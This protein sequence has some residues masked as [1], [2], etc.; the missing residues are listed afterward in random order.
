MLIIASTGTTDVV[1]AAML[2]LAVLL[3]WRPGASMAVL[4]V[5]GWFKL[6]PFALVP[7]WLAP[8][9][10]RRLAASIGSLAA[11]SA[12]A[13]ALALALG[14]LHGLAAMAHAVSYQLDR[15]SVQSPWAVLGITSVQPIA[16]A[17]VLA[18][19]AAAAVRLRYDH[20]L[21]GDRARIA[22]LSAAILLALELV[23]NYW[24]FLYLAWILPLIS[25]SLVADGCGATADGPGC[26]SVGGRDPA[27]LIPDAVTHERAAVLTR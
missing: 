14:G 11:V 1:L 24:T 26:T 27:A 16:Q 13:T 6:A 2:A 7:V 3:W 22:A 21:A 10:G 15:G 20:E 5:A 4:A 9:R 8:L 23:A 17:C 12:G 19:I 25:L 18:L